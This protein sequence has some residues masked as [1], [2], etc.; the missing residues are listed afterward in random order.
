MFW[1]RDDQEINLREIAIIDGKQYAI[2]RDC[3]GCGEF[4]KVNMQADGAKYRE[5]GR[6][7]CVACWCKEKAE[8]ACATPA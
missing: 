4:W 8:E 6:W 5:G 7:L 1:S 2:P 3:E